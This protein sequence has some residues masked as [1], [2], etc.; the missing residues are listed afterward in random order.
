[1][2]G[3]WGISDTGSNLERQLLI[4]VVKKLMILS[5][6]RGKDA[7][8]IAVMQGEELNVLRKAMS[9]R[10]LLQDLQFVRYLEENIIKTS[11]RN[12]WIT[13]HSKLITNSIQYSPNNNQP[14]AKKNIALVHNGIIVNEDELWSKMPE[15]HRDYEV[16]T[17]AILETFYDRHSKSGGAKQ[18]IES[19]YKDLRGMAS[20]ILLM[21]HGH[22]MIA[23][24]NNGSLYQVTSKDGKL[25]ILASNLIQ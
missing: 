10:E 22:H 11:G 1:M 16:D 2:C 25:T 23:A 12:L 24:S 14:V 6:T 15:T 5:E 9:S 13:G 18:A 20:T 21:Q 19:T 8:G 4:K 7:S 3:I 17:E